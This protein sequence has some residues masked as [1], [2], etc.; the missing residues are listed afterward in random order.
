MSCH[1]LSGDTLEQ[2]LIIMQTDTL[3]VIQER[4]GFLHCVSERSDALDAMG[5]N[6]FGGF[7]GTN[8]VD[9][10][11]GVM[12]LQRVEPLCL[13][14]GLEVA[15]RKYLLDLLSDLFPHPLDGAQIGHGVDRTREVFQ[16][17]ENGL[18]GSGLERCV[19]GKFS[20]SERL[21]RIQEKGLEIGLSGGHGEVVR[22]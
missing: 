8:T 5:L 9:T 12:R 20:L 7:G 17:L 15:R 16:L 19:E 18:I 3:L 14:C 1:F 11:E 10:L 6:Q 13:L 4:G 2:V 22:W 21:E